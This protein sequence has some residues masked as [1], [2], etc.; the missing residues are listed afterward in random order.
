M[1]AYKALW[2]DGANRAWS[3][4]KGSW[5]FYSKMAVITDGATKRPLCYP[6][7]KLAMACPDMKKYLFAFSTIQ[8]TVSFVENEFKGHFHGS[9][10]VPL[11]YLYRN[12]HIEIWE[13]EVEEF[14]LNFEQQNSQG[15]RSKNVYDDFIFKS[16]P[17]GTVF[18]ET[19]K[20]VRKVTNLK[21]FKNENTQV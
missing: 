20:L 6:K 10:Y 4:M 19:I 11:K 7:T 14:K 5:S 8:D 16:A 15:S 9:K 3:V 12:G 13:V 1:K 17:A 2:I 18:C 21:K